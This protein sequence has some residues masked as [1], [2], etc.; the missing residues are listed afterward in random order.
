MQKIITIGNNHPEETVW[1]VVKTF[2]KEDWDTLCVSALVLFTNELIHYLIVHYAPA[3]MQYP[4]YDGVSY[5]LLTSFAL[6]WVFG[7]AGQRL[8]YKILGTTENYL[9]NKIDQKLK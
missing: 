8:V 5:F 4:Y 3:L 7:Y 6:A 9:N 1:G 2:L